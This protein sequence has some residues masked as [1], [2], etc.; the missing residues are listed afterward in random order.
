MAKFTYK[1]RAMANPKGKPRVWFSCH[2]ADF[3]SCFAAVSDELLD[4]QN[5]AIWY[6]TEPEK[7]YDELFFTDLGQMQLFVL[8]VTRKLLSTPNRALDV[9]FPFAVE[10]HIPVLPL[11]QERGLESLFN[12]KCG[13]LQFL[14]KFNADPTAIGYGEKLKKY[15]ES[16][17]I[18]DDMAEKIRAAF[19]AYVF[20]S[21]RKKDRKY[22]QELMRLIHK[23][24]FCRD[25][26]IWYDEFLTP[27]EN[28]NDAIRE[29]LQ[30]S[31]LFVLTVTPN[32]V[33]EENY[34]M[35]MEYPMAQREGKS[36]LPAELVPTD[37]AL[38][39]EK[40]ENIPTCTNAHSEAEFSVALQNMAKDLAIRENDDSPEHNFFIGLAYLSGVDVEVDHNRALALITGA[41]KAG[42]PEAVSKLVEMYRTGLGVK[43]SYETAV[44]WQEKLAQIYDQQYQDQRSYRNGMLYAY[45]RWTL[46]G[47]YEEL[48][49]Y[50]KAVNC[51]VVAHAVYQGWGK[52]RDSVQ[53][54]VMAVNS[55]VRL[56]Q[57]YQG[58]GDYANA[59]KQYKK[60]M[61]EME[62]HAQTEEEL[63]TIASACETLGN[64]YLSE[65]NLP[66]AKEYYEKQCT[67]AEKMMQKTDNWLASM[68]LTLGYLHLGDVCKL[69]DE[70]DA[71]WE[72]IEK[73]CA[74]SKRLSEHE[75]RPELVR[76]FTISHLSMGMMHQLRGNVAAARAC[77]ETSLSNA[78]ELAEQTNSV[79]AR[80]DLVTLYTQLGSL[81]MED[82]SYADA[83]SY[84][85]KALSVG[86][87][88]VN[89]VKT[90]EARKDIAEIYRLLGDIYKAEENLP[91][92]R[93]YYENELAVINQTLRTTTCVLK[94]TASVDTCSS[95]VDVYLRLGRVCKQ[96]RD[97][98][99]SRKYY[100]AGLPFAESLA[101]RVNS[102]ETR[103]NIIDIRF[104]AGYIC[105]TDGDLPA[106]RKHLEPGLELAKKLA[107]ENG[108]TADW[109]NLALLHE[110]FG[111]LCRAEDNRTDTLENYNLCL[112]IRKVLAERTD[113]VQTQK[114]L[115]RITGKLEKL[116]Q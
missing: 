31:N 14:D 12:E 7:P 84:C 61:K 91:Q 44:E 39:A 79:D 107:T 68:E 99:G 33:N 82:G 34:V 48:R 101:E 9:E 92:A 16:V 47:Y 105:R 4:L 37:R 13:D 77:Y 80:K 70:Y 15:L 17:L 115:S 52:S 100:E 96:L 83:K 90:I 27:G 19:D 49:N 103:R 26:A 69:L 38:L 64:L 71:A 81:C 59:G 87:R 86:A 97:K 73:S 5:C 56:G 58:L 29:A 46:G 63:L 35:T 23:N 67:Y 40:Y 72:Y 20:L 95:L 3:D 22:A 41:A 112:A 43:R 116:K 2:P 60:A 94:P 66:A 53:A 74:L 11:M 76:I 85:T 108:S 21:Y 78:Q 10:H 109:K 93:T 88:L 36:I 30:K 57:M 110:A 51:F 104:N 28:F 8:P 98:T 111:D 106:A 6:D 62:G 32:L 75:N 18:G 102:I 45:S 54:Q 1:T 55:L 113:S 24:D 50:Q 42:L 114:A 25:I 89:E 65:Q